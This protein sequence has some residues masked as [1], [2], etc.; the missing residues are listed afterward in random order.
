MTAP[1]HLLIR[2]T[3]ISFQSRTEALR[4][5][6]QKVSA[7]A[8]ARV[9]TPCGDAEFAVSITHFYKSPPRCDADNMAKPICDA[10][11]DIVYDD[12]WQIVERVARR[13]PMS[14]SFTL[15]GMPRELALAL[16]EGDEFVYI[17]ITKVRTTTL[18][19]FWSRATQVAA[20]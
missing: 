14:R 2:G 5:W 16:C 11:N 13:I 3:P 10:L 19:A 17:R 4:E 15:W 18:S 9:D 1:I 7:A 20:W 6:K 12:D 8:R